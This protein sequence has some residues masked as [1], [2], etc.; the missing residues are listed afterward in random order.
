MENFDSDYFKNEILPVLKKYEPERIKSLIIFLVV[1][2]IIIA[3]NY[4][5]F[6]RSGYIDTSN[7]N[8]LYISSIVMLMGLTTLFPIWLVYYYVYKKFTTKLKEN[9]MKVILKQ[10]GNVKWKKKTSISDTRIKDSNIFGTYNIRID[11]DSFEGKYKDTEFSIV[12]T[13]LLNK[14]GSGKNQTIWPVFKGLIISIESNKTINNKTFITT[15]GDINT[16]NSNPLLW[17]LSAAPI[18]L[19]FISSDLFTKIA[20]AIFLIIFI[21]AYIAYTNHTKEK[22]ERITLED[23]EF[24]KKYNIYS[25]NQIEGRYLVTTAFMERFKNLHTTF[26]SRRAKCSFFDNEIMFAITTHRNLFEIGNI[27][28]PLTN[29]KRIMKFH[30]EISAIYELIDYFK[31]TEKIGL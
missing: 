29:E 5:L 21:A 24:N 30:K 2:I 13:T 7:T 25:S 1:S 28:L 8:M 20:A 12:E 23:P 16:R 27:F 3:I 31:L 22:I 15:K 4:V 10:F 18:L 14:K 9:C 6:S 19:F 17:I 11:G 26:G